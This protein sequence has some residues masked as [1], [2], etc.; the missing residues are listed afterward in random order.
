MGNPLGISIMEG[1]W[2]SFAGGVRIKK[3]K[4]G[5]FKEDSG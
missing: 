3:E 2:L 1:E 5:T 4:A